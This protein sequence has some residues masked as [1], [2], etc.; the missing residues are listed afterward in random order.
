MELIKNREIV[1]DTW[2]DLDDET[3]APGD[4]DIIVSFERLKREASALSERQGKLGVRLKSDQQASDIS[5][6]IGLLQL[7]AIEFPKFTDGRGYTTGRL[8]RDRYHFE[9]EL[10]ATG[11]VLRDQLFYMARCGF[12]S[13]VM[14]PGK[15]LESGL[16][17][18][19]DFSISY[20]AAADS[21]QPLF[22]RVKRS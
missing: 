17:A 16:K 20:Q 7:I 22:R 10:R 12:N 3:P 13:F 1:T 21:P 9:G 4:G 6:E 2:L 5:E 11:Y 18:F 15:S 8:L 19:D 14:A